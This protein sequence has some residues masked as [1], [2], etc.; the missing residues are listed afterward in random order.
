MRGDPV[1]T[2]SGCESDRVA[3][4]QW[5]DH[6]VRLTWSKKYFVKP[7]LDLVD[8]AVAEHLRQLAEVL[9]VHVGLGPGLGR[10]IAAAGAEWL[11]LAR[12]RHLAHQTHARRQLIVEAPAA[13]LH[14]L[15]ALELDVERRIRRVPD[16]RARL[17]L[18]LEVPEEVQLVAQDRTAERER[19]LLVVDR[20]HAVQHRVLRVE[21]A[22]A[23][24]AADRAGE[25]CWCP[26]A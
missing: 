11:P 24:V 1:V 4:C 25:A 21:P 23:E 15:V 13:Q 5:F 18:V 12:L 20:H 9:A 6:V 19:D 3:A 8:G 22:V 7:A 14:R 17:A 10:M 26:S 2:P 16:A